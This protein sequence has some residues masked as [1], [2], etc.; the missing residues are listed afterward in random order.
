[1]II[2]LLTGHHIINFLQ[3][4]S[5][6]QHD[7]KSKNKK[8]QTGINKKNRIQQENKQD[9]QQKTVRVGICLKK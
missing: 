5:N 8:D 6:T 3:Q 2:H 7:V 9:S 1:M 4:M